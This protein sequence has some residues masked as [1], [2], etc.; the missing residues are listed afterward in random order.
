MPA[1][2]G[3]LNGCNI[4]R[5]VF[6]DELLKRYDQARELLTIRS[7]KIQAQRAV[8]CSAKGMIQKAEQIDRYSLYAI[9]VA[10]LYKECT[11]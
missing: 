3:R 8:R 1:Y 9:I 10:S 11:I 4:Y 2:F 7:P 6:S 5:S